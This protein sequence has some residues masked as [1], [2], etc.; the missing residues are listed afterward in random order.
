MLDFPRPL[1][2]K[3]NACFCEILTCWGSVNPP[4]PS[5]STLWRRYLAV[6]IRALQQRVRFLAPNDWRSLT[7][8]TEDILQPR[9]AIACF[10]TLPGVG[11]KAIL[12][13]ATLTS[14]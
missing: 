14:G 9:L 13:Q 10:S 12:F 6:G 5:T 7:N 1:G 8:W 2:P 11:P 3:T 4:K